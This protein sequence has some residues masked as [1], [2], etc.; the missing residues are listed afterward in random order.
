MDVVGQLDRDHEAMVRRRLGI[1][2]SHVIKA[3]NV[4]FEVVPCKPNHGEAS[5]VGLKSLGEEG[6]ET[7]EAHTSV[8]SCSAVNPRRLY[9]ARLVHELST[10]ERLQVEPLHHG[11]PG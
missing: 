11:R 3:R 1:L 5:Q 2:V 4:A 6:E 7:G 10:V 9:V 8:R